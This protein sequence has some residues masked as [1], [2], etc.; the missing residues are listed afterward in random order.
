M[1]EAKQTDYKG[2]T[3]RSKLEAE[4]CVF[5]DTLGVQYEYEPKSFDLGLLNP[6]W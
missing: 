1:I 4:W 6:S 2:V 5:F 3:Y